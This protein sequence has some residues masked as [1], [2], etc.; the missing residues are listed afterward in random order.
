MKFKGRCPLG[1]IYENK[2]FFLIR[3]DRARVISMGNDIKFTGIHQPRSNKTYGNKGESFFL[4]V[5]SIFEICE[6]TLEKY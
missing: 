4:S 2:K 1:M 3:K 5:F 6:K